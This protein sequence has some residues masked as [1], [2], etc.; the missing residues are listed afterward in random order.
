MFIPILP[1]LLAGLA[2]ASATEVQI[3]DHGLASRRNA[4]ALE[5]AKQK[6]RLSE[7]DL[8]AFQEAREK[9][10]D[11]PHAMKF[12]EAMEKELG[13]APS[14][15]SPAPAPAEAAPQPET[16]PP[17]LEADPALAEHAYES[18]DYETALAHY[19]AL[20]A[21]GDPYANLILG[22]MYQ[23]GQGVDPDI[24]AAH[25]YYGRAA[26][27]GDDR[28]AELIETIERRM[29]EEEKAKA[30]EEYKK[31][32]EEQKQAGAPEPPPLEEK[33]RYPRVIIESGRPASP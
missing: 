26:E 2:P 16:Q 29:S 3:T 14:G 24:A 32:A 10:K 4:Q 21:Q 28:G 20:A 6:T 12:I 25:A 7:E 22:L 15:T 18:G 30:E 31:I 33:E 27:Y 17:A 5:E 8:K 9:Y 1:L 13:I 11:N 23:Q 19:K